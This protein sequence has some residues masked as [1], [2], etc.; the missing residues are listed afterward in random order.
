MPQPLPNLPGHGGKQHQ[1]PSNPRCR[2]VG[3]WWG[4]V[5]GG[6]AGSGDVMRLDTGKKGSNRIGDE[7]RHRYNGKVLT[8]LSG[9][10]DPNPTPGHYNKIFRLS[11]MLKW[12]CFTHKERKTLGYRH[13]HW[14]THTHALTHPKTHQHT[15]T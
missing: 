13:K 15:Q 3:G 8:G 10:M 1:Q 9:Y 2:G 5:W 12:S 14:C 11:Q 7:Y 6:R 4:S